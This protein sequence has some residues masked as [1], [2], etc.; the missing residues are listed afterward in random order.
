MPKIKT[1][2]SITKRFKITKTGKVLRRRNFR[3]HLK[4][5]KSAKRIRN[6]KQQVLVKEAFAKRIRKRMGVSLK[7]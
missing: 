4:S 6:L 3:R 1:R 5:S 2:K 7:K